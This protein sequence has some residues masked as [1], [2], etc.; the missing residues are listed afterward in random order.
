MPET[1]VEMVRFNKRDIVSLETLPSAQA[2]DPIIVQ[3]HS[4]RSGPGPVR[5]FVRACT[6]VMLVLV[7]LGAGVLVAIEQGFIDRFLHDRAQIALSRIAGAAYKAELTSAGIR[8]ARSG[9]LALEA[10]NVSFASLNG[11]AALHTAESVRLVLEPK[12]LLAGLIEV[13]SVEVSGVVL[14]GP[15]GRRVQFSDLAGLRVDA[16]EGLLETAFAGLDRLW[17]G[18]QARQTRR[19]TINSL[20]LAG[21][22]GAEPLVIDSAELKTTAGRGLAFEGQVSQGERVFSVTATAVKAEGRSALA[23]V[24]GVIEGIDID[25]VSGGIPER[26]MGAKTTLDFTFLVERASGQAKPVLRLSAR[27]SPG[28][29]TL[30][31][32]PAELRDARISL[33]YDPDVRKIEIEAS[34]LRVGDTVLPFAGGLIDTVRL[35]GAVDSGISFDLV[36]TDGIAAPGDSEDQPTRFGAKAFGRFLPAERRIVADQLAV[37]TNSGKMVGSASFRFVADQSPEINIFAKTDRLATTAV[38]QLWPYWLGKQARQWVLN[39]LYGGTV[40]NGEIELALPAGLFRP[41]GREPLTDAQFR[42][43]FDIERARLNV[44]GDIPPLRDTIGH[45][46]LRGSTVEVE[47]S[48][49]TAYFP[50]GRSVAVSDG[51][52][53]I[54]ATDEQPLMADIRMAVSGKA[55]AV[56]ELITYHPVAALD[57]IELEPSD[58]SGDITADVKARFGLVQAQSPPPPV[59]AVDLNLV[60]V[61]IAKPIEGR[62]LAGVNGSLV[63]TPVRAE[64]KAD[65]IVDGAPLTLDVV[66]PIG[67]SDV[68]RSRRISGTLDNGA[69]EK[70]APG[71]GAVL[72]GPVGFSLT[73]KDGGGSAVELDL[74]RA[75]VT[76]PGFG[77]SKGEGIRAKASFDLETSGST[78]KLAGL[79]LSGEGFGLSGDI[80]I[81]DGK[82]SRAV[83]SKVALSPKDNFRLTVDRSGA[84]YALAVGGSSIDVRPLIGS[85][86]TAIAGTASGD[87]AA[88]LISVDGKVDTVYGFSD[89]G[90]RSASF[91]YAGRGNRI[92]IL[93]FKAVTRS[94]QAAI[95]A[96]SGS[97]GSESLNATSGDAGA[98][99][100]F[101]GFYGKLQGGLLNVRLTR[102]GGASRRGVVDIRNFSIVGEQKLDSLVSARTGANGRSLKDTANGA[103]DLSTAQFDVATARIDASAGRLSVSDGIIRGNA[104]GASFQG[105]VYDKRGNI[106][107]TGTFMPAYGINRLFAELPLIG[108]I[109]GNGRD[110]GLIGITFRLIGKASAPT[111]EVNPL[112]IIAPGVFRSIFE[113]AP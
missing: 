83:F 82:L 87:A 106:D 69:R 12:A 22:E 96:I 68:K 26:R 25:A 105:T 46:R 74:R 70:L 107:M 6:V 40:S 28:T 111:V 33:A 94:G 88:P 13:A 59:W 50:T 75:V 60:G 36:V 18:M 32:V 55:D 9:R 45:V 54:P 2:E 56:A 78:V 72:S 37:A 110:R 85:A 91:R 4:G 16:V 38:K 11:D 20:T 108:A 5:K 21:S 61:D 41:D 103:L 109:L 66:Q 42:I 53:S 104:I 63:V 81:A 31:G 1:P 49:A 48:S 24:E 86:K 79:R 99:A 47:V 35:P 51:T 7:V 23:E 62:R 76:V 15:S 58:L 57:R 71:S 3:A 92:D 102:E 27:A 19:L 98:F 113:Y 44:A 80:T 67:G 101:A 97:G 84:G 77:W 73:S 29:I 112:S 8:L 39:N 93:D 64:L 10:R 43:D 89:E 95:L 17:E 90:L 65:A 52:F 34:I 14:T 100:R 30:G